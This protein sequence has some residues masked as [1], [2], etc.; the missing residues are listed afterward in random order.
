LLKVPGIGPTKRRALLHVF[1]SVQGVKEATIDQIAAIPGFGPGTARRLLLALG[2]PIPEDT[3][4]EVAP[5][6]VTES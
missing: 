3:A 5:H 4:P 6:P 2:V 1:G